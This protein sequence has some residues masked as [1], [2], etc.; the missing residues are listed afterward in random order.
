MRKTRPLPPYLQRWFD[1]RTGKTY[2]QFRKRGHPLTALPQPIGSDE[3]WRAY[4]AALA[5]KAEI[6]AER[7]TAGSVAA[8]IA[9]YFASTQWTTLSDGTRGARRAILE[10]FRGK[11][12]TWPLRQIT[13]NFL[14]AYLESFSPH[15]AK[16]TLKAL[17][18]F[19]QHARH[20]VTRDIRTAR[21]PNKRHE[22]WPPEMIARFE[23]HHPIG[24]K[25]RL[26]F[27][28][29]RYTGAGRSEIARMGPQHIVDG[30][31]ARRER[32]DRA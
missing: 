16:N 21:T 5:S 24:T 19:L 30:R 31:G 7:S 11:Y 10:R 20:D 18:G 12:G 4:N 23:A 32:F 27:A 8:A 17:R 22:S 2:L 28:L 14:N 29:A 15:A 6:G 13:E 9:G 3:F 26:V 25:P 1:R